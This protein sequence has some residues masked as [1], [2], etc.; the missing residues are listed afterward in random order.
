LFVLDSEPRLCGVNNFRE[1]THGI[2]PKFFKAICQHRITHIFSAM[3]E[4]EMFKKRQ[5]GARFL[6]LTSL[7]PYL[8]DLV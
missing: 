4:I 7:N 5:F 8:F 1:G 3:H 2:S 6:I